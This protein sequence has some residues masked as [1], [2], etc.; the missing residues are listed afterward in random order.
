MTYPAF[1]RCGLLRRDFV[2]LRTSPH[3]ISATRIHT[4][5]AVAVIL[6]VNL[7]PVPEL[8]DT[9]LIPRVPSAIR[10]TSRTRAWRGQDWA[11]MERLYK[12]G[13]IADPQNEAKSVG[14]TEE[15]LEKSRELFE[16]HFARKA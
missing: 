12:A 9:V 7:R 8:S 13:Y 2:S 14:M 1:V 16:G 11:A 5:S 4:R 10:Q 15:R 3:R 6:V